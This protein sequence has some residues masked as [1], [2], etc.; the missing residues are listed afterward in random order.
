M[1]YFNY[2]KQKALE[3]L[4]VLTQDNIRDIIESMDKGGINKPSDC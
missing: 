1:E 4:E 2:S 3:A